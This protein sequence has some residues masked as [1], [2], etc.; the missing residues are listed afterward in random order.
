MLEKRITA[1]AHRGRNAV[2]Q[3]DSAKLSILPEKAAQ[4]APKTPIRQKRRRY[5]A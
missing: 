2:R 5:D 1:G 3:A 4:N